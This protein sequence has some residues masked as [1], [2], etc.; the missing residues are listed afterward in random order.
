MK[1]ILHRPGHFCQ[2]CGLGKCRM[3]SCGGLVIRM[4]GSAKAQKP[5]A[6]RPQIDNLPHNNVKSTLLAVVKE[7]WRP[8]DIQSY[9]SGGIRGVSRVSDDAL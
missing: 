5:I 8:L 7:R 3:A 1:R 2:I 6:N 4:G 9:R